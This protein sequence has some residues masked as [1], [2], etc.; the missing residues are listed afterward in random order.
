VFNSIVQ[1]ESDEGRALFSYSGLCIAIDNYNR[2]HDE[3]FAL[4][5]TEEQVGTPYDQIKRKEANIN[6]FLVHLLV[7]DSDGA[8]LVSGSYFS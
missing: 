5:G 6:T 7:T 2:Y 1:P 4:M 8:C 3:K